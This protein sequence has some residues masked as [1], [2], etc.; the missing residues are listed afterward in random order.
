MQLEARLG[1]LRRPFAGWTLAPA[2]ALPLR[3]LVGVWLALAA[4]TWAD[5]AAMADQWW[6]SSTFSHILLIPP[7][8][9][10]LVHQRAGELAR[11]PPQ[12]WWPGLVPFAGA[13]LLWV[14]G[15]FSGLTLARELG[16]VAMLIAS[17]LALLGPRAGAGLAFPLGYMLF[18][19]PFGEEL[20][21][22]MQMVTAKLT[23]G[24]VHL[25]GMTAR[26]DGVFIDTPA[27]L[28]QVA[29]ACSGIKFL[30]AM[31][32]F[33]ALA[34]NLCFKSWWRRAL[35]MLLCIAVPVLANGLRAWGTIY[36]AQY[37]GAERA[38]GIDH[39]FY[40]WVFFGLVIALTMAIAWKFFDRP[41]DDAMID[42]D[43]INRSPRLAAW[44]RHTASWPR[45]LGGIAGI[46]LAGQAWALAAD[47]LSAPM[48]RHIALPEVP[49]W[50]R[51][52]FRPQAAWEPR[53]SGADHRLLGRYAD[54]RGHEVDVFLA[55]YASQSEGKEAGGFGEGALI[56]DSGWAWQSSGP[57]AQD[58][59][60]D[61]LLGP[62]RV[63]RLAQTYYRTGSLVTGSNARLKLA[64]IADRLLLR[65]RPTATLI[66]SAEERPGQ[67]AAAA[68]L[69]AF[70]RSTGAPGAW[71]DRI[72]AIR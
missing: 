60:S 39:I 70:R 31:M 23:I 3:L 13:V 71:M 27:G 56:A 43:A 58:A 54:G 33:G 5:W 46:A 49:G 4:S 8:L 2:W 12:H 50:H 44:A 63:E 30:V 72:T 52:D 35:F 67:P 45:T 34:A 1:A 19:V 62:G 26:I 40:G 9:A 59:K 17:A 51:T 24:L 69:D 61:R 55:L 41:R 22:P 14:L 32:A 10:W 48:P 68:S 20:V 25:A 57:S 6:N 66:L 36:I 65:A 21:A 37:V 42:P 7:I 29:E 47:S 28:F 15:A 11:V 53:A 16:A 64:N 38:T 18:L